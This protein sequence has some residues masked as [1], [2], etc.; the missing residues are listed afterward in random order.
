MNNVLLIIL[1]VFTS[2]LPGTAMADVQVGSLNY[3]AITTF[4]VFVLITLGISYWASK[5]TKNTSQF[6]TAGGQITA[7]QN[8]TAIAGDF[9]SAASFLGISGLIYSAGYDGLI[10]AVGALSGWPLMLFLMSERVRNLGKF[11]FTDVVSYRLDKKPI[12]MTA[13]LGSITVTIFYL[14]A[15]L[16]GAGKLIVLLFG[17]S[18][19]FA[20]GIIG[21][22][23]MIYVTIGGMLATTWVQIVKATLLL[24]GVTLMC[25]ILLTQINFDFNFIFAKAAEVHAKGQLILQPGSLFTDPI[26]AITIAVSMMCGLLGLPHVLMRLFT[27]KD[28][29]TAKKSVFVASGLMGYFYLLTILIGFSAIIFVSTNPNFF[30]DGKLIG[31]TNM[32][33]IHLSQVLGGDLLMGFMSAVAFATILAVVAGLI[34][35]GS[36]AVS[37]DVYAELICKGN[38]DKKKELT[39]SRISA[40]VLCAIGVLLA[41]LF[42]N[43]NVAFIAVMPLVIAASVNFPILILAMY[44]KKLTTRGAVTGGLVGFVSSISLIIM[45]PKVWVSVIGAD[46]P[47][48]PYDYPGLF[49]ITAAIITM[50]VVSLLDRSKRAED[51]RRLFDKQL[52]AAELATDVAKA[53][54]H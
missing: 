35:A 16:V 51:D 22:L 48:F 34:V 45:G 10:L 41:V 11:T 23:V 17:L 8:G 53:V 31:G 1:A 4:V 30:A 20:V 5:H 3:S 6:Y 39:L 32:V 29:N 46:A 24:L 27:V 12:K 42:Q 18:Y 43:Q 26:Q 14:V 40:V 47:L 44:W 7:T 37:H 38:P 2:S 19:E 13:T 15:Q 50:V 36:A 28:M 9:M 54:D 25:L 49:T 52:I 21:V 33:A